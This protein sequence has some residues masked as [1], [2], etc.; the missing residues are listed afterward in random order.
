MIDGYSKIYHQ[1]HWHLTIFYHFLLMP[2]KQ[3]F[4][5][6]KTMCN[7]DVFFSS[8]EVDLNLK[9]MKYIT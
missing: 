3:I 7:F 4:S 8:S 6:T 5:I 2:F 1:S 9:C